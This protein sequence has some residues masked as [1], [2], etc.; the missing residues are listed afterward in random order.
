MYKRQTIAAVSVGRTTSAGGNA[1]DVSL[2]Y[3]HQGGGTESEVRRLFLAQHGT[4]YLVTGDA[5]VG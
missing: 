5:V 3:T 1:V 4:S 2:T